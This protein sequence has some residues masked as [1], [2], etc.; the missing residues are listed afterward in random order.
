VTH[1]QLTRKGVHHTHSLVGQQRVYSNT[2][3]RTPPLRQEMNTQHF[4]HRSQDGRQG[5]KHS[6]KRTVG[7]A[8][9]CSAKENASSSVSDMAPKNHTQPRTCGHLRNKKHQPPL[10]MLEIPEELEWRVCGACAGW[11][12]LAAVVCGWC[13]PVLER[14][15]ILVSF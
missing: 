9:S 11:V 2:Q 6:A 13:L 10:R 3:K 15:I 14:L 7:T 4:R 5:G 12:V 8:K 1:Q